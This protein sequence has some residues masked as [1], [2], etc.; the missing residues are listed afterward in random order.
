MFTVHELTLFHFDGE[1]VYPKPVEAISLG[2]F[3][4]VQQAEHFLSAQL[5]SHEALWRSE[6]FACLTLEET[7]VDSRR[8][9][10]RR[11]FYDAAGEF[12]GEIKVDQLRKPFHGREPATCLFC[13]GELVQFLHQEELQ[14]GIVAGLPLSPAEVAGFQQSW[15]VL[16]DEDCYL[17]LMGEEDHVHLRECE[18]FRPAGHIDTRT[19][20]LL[21]SRFQG[22][23]AV[24][25]R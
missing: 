23:G 6:T 2:L 13:Q 1:L 24:D 16:G 9:F 7:V 3:T 11:R 17:V 22:I 8:R 18:V 19:R 14:V 15:E 5:A 25:E 20:E 21:M 12:N 10:L 4:T